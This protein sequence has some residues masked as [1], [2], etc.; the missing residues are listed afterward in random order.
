MQRI[1]NPR[2]INASRG[3]TTTSSWRWRR[4]LMTG[5]GRRPTPTTC[6]LLV[7]SPPSSAGSSRIRPRHIHDPR[8]IGES[9]VVGL[10]YLGGEGLAG[11]PAAVVRRGGAGAVL[12]AAVLGRAR[13]ARQ[14]F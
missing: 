14:H 13:D 3:G 9:A 2:R 6:P 8:T 12:I 4:R 5:R 10:R 11:V 7:C 1:Q